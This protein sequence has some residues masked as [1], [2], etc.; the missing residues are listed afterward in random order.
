MTFKGNTVPSLS[1]SD[2]LNNIDKN[3]CYLFVKSDLVNAFKDDT[4]W[5]KI[6]NIV[7]YDI[8]V[9][10][11]KAEVTTTTA[12]TLEDYIGDK[13][14]SIN[15]L[16][17]KGPLNAKDIKCLREM[18][19]TDA[20][21]NTTS[22]QLEYLNLQEASIA[23][24]GNTTYLA[25]GKGSTGNGQD[26]TTAISS[27]K[28]NV[29]P[30]YAF[31]KCPKLKTILL[32]ASVTEIGNSAL[33]GCENLVTVDMTA[34]KFTSIAHNA[35]RSSIKITS[36]A[37]PTTVS[38]IANDAF[39]ET[40]A[41][42]AFSL[43]GYNNSFEV[44]EGVLFTSEK[45][46]LVAFPIGKEITSY[47]VPFGT[48]RISSCSFSYSTLQTLTLPY[49]ITELEAWAFEETKFQAITIPATLST[50]GRGAFLGCKS[51]VSL[52]VQNPTPPT[53]TD[54]DGQEIDRAN[55]T[56][57]VPYQKKD[58]YGKAVYWNG[59]KNIKEL[60]DVIYVYT[61]GTL[62][63]SILNVGLTPTELT[64]L[65]I[66]GELNSTDIKYLRE[67]AG[68]DSYGVKNANTNLKS[69]N[70]GQATI[71]AGGESYLQMNNKSYTTSADCLGEYA[72]A[73]TNLE[74]FRFPANI[75]TVN[76]NI[77]E[78][79]TELN[80]IAFVELP[81][82]I[83]ANNAKQLLDTEQK[84]GIVIVGTQETSDVS[85]VIF[86][87]DQNASVELMDKYNFGLNEKL[88]L[89]KCTFTKNFS[90]ATQDRECLGWET[91]ILPFKP[92]EIRGTTLKKENVYLVPFDSDE[93]AFEGEKVRYFWLRELTTEG[94]K[95][96]K[97]ENIEPYK[98][99]IISMPNS[100]TDYNNTWNIVGD[101]LFIADA[102]QGNTIELYPT[103]EPAVFNGE[104]F[105]LT[106]TFK[107]KAQMAD[108]YVI[109]KEGSAFDLISKVDG[110]NN[111]I[112]AFE[113]YAQ[114]TNP[115][116]AGI[117]RLPINGRL[118]VPSGIK[119]VM[120]NDTEKAGS[121]FVI[122]QTSNGLHIV[123]K[124][125]KSIKIYSIEGRLISTERISEGDNYITLPKGI[126]LIEK[127]KA[128][129]Y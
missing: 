122:R 26:I 125:D 67:L 121:N 28:Q 77:F 82:G 127:L 15:H 90:K 100:P 12:G 118:D 46:G 42:K 1:S 39:V 112:D 110:K 106:A 63:S 4:E 93:S 105:S 103:T 18:A 49:G 117:A 71:S 31:F 61:P 32:P 120:M 126:Y 47:T 87:N 79:A 68:V 56:L 64:S 57:Y 62:Q 101:V 16:T 76:Q 51:V 102:G 85:N 13:K 58:A 53:V 43:L 2:F 92:T 34:C 123:S 78:N 80:C 44:Q 111:S 17:I 14:N 22:G 83:S 38:S 19:G 37:L 27:T 107:K 119:D 21:L 72:F 30:D 99:Y 104:S 114:I 20:N 97:F 73:N 6:K 10:D 5:R 70:L 98:P 36:F 89:N 86:S 9:I 129:V 94:F 88:P 91:I 95:D 74:T 60:S 54:L 84:N 108:V 45:E 48:K 113:A 52:Y 65:M 66:H 55:C 124:V 41:N 59:F 33:R 23:A 3:T 109:N 50:I 40:K 96:V 8:T 25:A 69:I 35:F 75:S 116:Y 115:A 11:G 24:G 29:F 128:V 81:T 7:A